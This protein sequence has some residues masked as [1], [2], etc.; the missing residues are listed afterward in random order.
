M[1]HYDRQPFL[2]KC[3]RRCHWEGAGLLSP[4]TV[5]RWKRLAT[6]MRHA[7]QRQWGRERGNGACKG[8]GLVSVQLLA[9]NG[10]LVFAD[11]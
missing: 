9:L 3:V 1:P 7:R 8:S 11:R 6:Y 4:L 5:D 2:R 10:Q